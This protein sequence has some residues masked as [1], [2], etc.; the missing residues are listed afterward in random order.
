MPRMPFREQI[1][2]S[3]RPRPSTD[4]PS[5]L[6]FAVQPVFPGYAIEQVVCSTGPAT[7]HGSGPKAV[8]TGLDTLRGGV[9]A[10]V[11]EA[12]AELRAAG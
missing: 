1:V 4:R 10:R 6:Q 5:N 11:A 3:A 12:E 7:G 8:W 2:C 9:L